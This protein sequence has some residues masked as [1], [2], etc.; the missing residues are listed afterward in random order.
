[1]AKGLPI[2][3]A[4]VDAAGNRVQYPG[5]FLNAERSLLTERGWVYDPDTTLWSPP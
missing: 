3:D 4:S 1:M 2:R 5:S